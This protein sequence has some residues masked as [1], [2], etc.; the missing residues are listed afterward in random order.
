MTIFDRFF[1]D[2]RRSMIGWTISLVAV[3]G[4]QNAF[5]PAFKEQMSELDF[6]Q[7]F[8][9]FF[10]LGGLSIASPAGWLQAQIF[11][12]FPVLLTIF[13]VSIGTRALATSEEDGT[14]EL[15]LAN[16]VERRR[17]AL[18]RALAGGVLTAIVGFVTTALILL[19][20]P[21]LGLLEGVSLPGYAAESLSS[22]GIALLF[23][24]L[25]FMVGGLTGRRTLSLT[26]GTAVAV[27]TYIL[28]G[29]AATVEVAAPLRF[30]TP[31]HWM[32]GRN[33]LVQGVAVEGVTLPF[34]FAAVFVAVGVWAFNRRDLQTT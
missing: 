16:P 34:A 10:G 31:F 30:I 12:I 17:V 23:G 26:V 33:M 9:D 3:L 22:V 18:H 19:T 20:C 8:E 14:M 24:G 32:L 11:A 1:T 13:A 15:L 2:R 28:N 4:L 6:G 7:G 5:Y 21:P 27:A 25:A 29:L